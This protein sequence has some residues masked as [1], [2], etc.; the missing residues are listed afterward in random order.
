MARG[1]DNN[2]LMKMWASLPKDWYS[3]YQ[4][5]PACQSGY[6]EM[7]SQW[8]DE[9]F[10]T[11]RLVP[12]GLRQRSFRARNHRGQINLQTKIEQITEK[13]LL[14]AMFNLTE[15]P[16]LGKVIDYEVPLKETNASRHGDIDILCVQSSSAI[17]IEAKK[18]RANESVL[19]A[20]LQA[21]TYT[22]LIAPCKSRFLTDFGLSATLQLTPGVLTFANTPSGRQLKTPAKW[23][24]LFRLIRTLNSDLAEREVARMKFYV[25]ENDD[26]ELDNC[27]TT[28]TQPNG[29]VKAVFCDGLVL[30]INEYPLP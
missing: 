24:R 7:I 23:P 29:D 8:I 10:P 30:T 1:L 14:R 13:R 18:P 12:D 26:A 19:K 16:K 3:I 11:I 9:S 25:V 21:F 6:T 5:K 2:T 28:K 17:C 20:I 22:S 27:L 4:W 15:L